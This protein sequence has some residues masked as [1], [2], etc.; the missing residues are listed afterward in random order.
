MRSRPN[1][2]TASPALIPWI[3]ALTLLF[4]ANVLT[5]DLLSSEK[6]GPTKDASFTQAADG[7]HLAGRAHSPLLKLPA[8]G[9]DDVEFFGS[10]CS[11][12]LPVPASDPWV[13]QSKRGVV[14]GRAP[15]A[16]AIA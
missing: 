12:L 16:V 9:W 6:R 8:L 11:L 3:I 15:P 7:F 2:H 5:P 10:G 14:Q 4:G 1:I 13:A